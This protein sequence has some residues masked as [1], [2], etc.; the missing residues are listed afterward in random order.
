MFSFEM[1]PEQ[2]EMKDLARKFAADE[3][4][5]VAPKY[6]EEERFPAD[7]CRKAWELGLMNLEVPKEYGGAGLGVLDTIL[8]LEELN[9]GCAGVTNALAANGLATVPLLL[10]GND[11]QKRTYLGQLVSEVTFAAFCTTEPGAGSDVAG[12]STTYRK[13]GDEYVLNGVKHFISN[14]TVASWYTVFATADK[15]LRHKGVSCFVIP[16]DT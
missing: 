14:G 5:P 2:R 8:I 3:I 10:A 13:V 12:M 1:T 6:D 9:Y 7:L 16:A 15:A 11:E 4:I